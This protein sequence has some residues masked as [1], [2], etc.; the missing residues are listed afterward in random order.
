MKKSA[1]IPVEQNR[2]EQIY[3]VAARIFCEKGFDAASMSDIAEA[4]GIT[5]AGIYHYIP[6]GKKDLLYAIMSYGMDRLEREVI[7]PARRIPDAE[8]RLRAM[9]AN[10]ARIILQGSTPNGHNP[11]TILNDEVAGLT[12]VQRRKIIQRKRVYVDLARETLE[13]LKAENKLK[14][15]DP[16]VASFSIFG[17]LLWLSRWYRPDGQLTQEQVVDEMLKLAL[18]AVLRAPARRRK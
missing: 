16:T 11:V 14:D 8:S 5:K 7:V 4:V 2:L 15:V 10:H 18:G 6:G 13:Q 9:V 1:E 3:R 17:M 12:P